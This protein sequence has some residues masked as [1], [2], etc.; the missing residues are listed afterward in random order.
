MWYTFTLN[1]EQE[2]THSKHL[3]Y[4]SRDRQAFPT[5]QR[6]TLCSVPCGALAA[7]LGQN[8]GGSVRTYTRVLE[9]WHYW[10]GSW[11]ILF[12]S[13]RFYAFRMF[14]SISDVYQLDIPSFPSSS[15][16][17]QPHVPPDI[18]ICWLILIGRHIT[19]SQIHCKHIPLVSFLKLTLYVLKQSD[20]KQLNC[21]DEKIALLAWDFSY[22]LNGTEEEDA[23]V[24]LQR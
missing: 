9:P 21:T 2:N 22:V 16:R 19:K 13:G 14:I 15:T 10:F 5:G 6:S 8:P 3:V 12:C 17:R 11:M 18:E 23:L 20:P 4:L 1:L 24:I 7:D